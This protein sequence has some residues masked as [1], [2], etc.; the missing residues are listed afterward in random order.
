[1]IYREDVI[2]R[3]GLRKFVK[4]HIAKAYYSIEG[5]VAKPDH[6]DSVVVIVVGCAHSGTTLTAAKLGNH[7]EILAIGRET[8][9]LLDSHNSKS[10]SS[11]IL[12]EWEYFADLMSKRVIVE[13]TPKHLYCEKKLLEIAP[14]SKVIAMVRNPLDV[15]ESLYRRFGDLNYSIERWC[16]DNEHILSLKKK[17][18]CRKQKL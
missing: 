13:K 1:M 9:F 14:N 16:F 3:V 11:R 4:R 5:W 2:H 7:P 10:C 8:C 18:Q 12:R 6:T 17:K 15:V